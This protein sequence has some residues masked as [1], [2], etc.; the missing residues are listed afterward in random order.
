[1]LFSFD[2][3]YAC[4]SKEILNI[5][6]P[7]RIASSMHAGCCATFGKSKAQSEA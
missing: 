5:G 7:C 3:Y 2:N 6:F 1:M 4:M